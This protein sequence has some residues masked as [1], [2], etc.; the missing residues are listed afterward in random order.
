MKNYKILFYFLSISLQAGKLLQRL[1][2]QKSNKVKFKMELS[3]PSSDALSNT[4]AEAVDFFTP[5]DDSLEES[6]ISVS[7][8]TGASAA[9]LCICNSPYLG[10]ACAACSLASCLCCCALE[11]EKNNPKIITHQPKKKL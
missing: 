1:G 6:L 3:L 2:I 8:V 9:I 10:T 4:L 7:K 11:E 5:T